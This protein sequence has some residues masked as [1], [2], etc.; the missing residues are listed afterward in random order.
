M[1]VILL[2]WLAPVGR[3]WMAE[4]RRRWRGGPGGSRW[5]V[6]GAVVWV[7]RGV[8]VL[9]SSGG[10]LFVVCVVVLIVSAGV[11]A[12]VLGQE[13]SEEP[14]PRCDWNP[15]A[16]ECEDPPPPTATPTGR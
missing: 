15:F 12:A 14:R 11:S 8:R 4:A 5:E 13:E 16:V 6:V 9:E 2:A 3:G 1:W 7:R 10:R